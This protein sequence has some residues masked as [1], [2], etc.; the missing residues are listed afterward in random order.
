LHRKG[1]AAEPM[2]IGA[3]YKLASIGDTA[4]AIKHLGQALYTDRE[5]VRRAATYGLIA[6]G[7]EATATFLEAATSPIRWVRKAG[8]Y[9]LGDTSQ[10]SK[11]VLDVVAMRLREDSSVYV[12]SVAAGTLGCL[13]RRAISTGIGKDLI[14]ACLDALIESLGREQN[15]LAMDL[16]QGRSIKFARPTDDCDV[17]EGN[18]VDFD[19]A[20]FKKVRSAVRENALWSVVIL[21]SHGAQATGAAFDSTITA[22]RE[23]IRTDENAISVGF[24]M[25]A[26]NRLANLGEGAGDLRAN[27]LP[28]LR[29]SPIQAWE[30]LVR[31]GLGVDALAEIKAGE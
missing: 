16:A 6:V 26:L 13:G 9:G 25:D 21:C 30:A 24:A 28:M 17:C 14:P 29:E 3:A 19:H 5:S 27:L 23:V 22:L 10:L 12:R 4:L 1:N 7:E 18:G 8:V 15:R 20:R 2:R 31:G 11:E